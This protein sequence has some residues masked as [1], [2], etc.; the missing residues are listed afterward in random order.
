MATGLTTDTTPVPEGYTYV[1]LLPQQTGLRQPMYTMVKKEVVERDIDPETGTDRS[2]PKVRANLYDNRVSQYGIFQPRTKAEAENLIGMIN[3]E[4]AKENKNPITFNQFNYVTDQLANSLQAQEAVYEE[5]QKRNDPYKYYVQKF[6]D[7][8]DPEKH[9]NAIDNTASIFQLFRDPAKFAKDKKTALSQMMRNVIP[10]TRNDFVLAG[11]VVGSLAGFKGPKMP[12]QAVTGAKSVADEVLEG[13]IFKTTAGATLGGTAMSLTYDL[14]NAGIRKTMGIADPEDAPNAALEALTHGRNTLYFTGGAAG[15]MGVASTFRPFLGKALFGLD[16]PRNTLSN[17]A[18]LYD[19][20]VGISQMTRGAGGKLSGAAAAYFRVVGKIPFFGAGFQSRNTLAGIQLTKGMKQQLGDLGSGQSDEPLID[21]ISKSY[22]SLPRAV[23]KRMDTD[24]RNAGFRSYKDMVNAELRV[25]ELAPIQHMTDVGAFMFEEA[26]KRYKQFAY[27]NDLLY[28]D[29]ENKAKKISKNFIPTANTKAV[30]QNVRDELADATI[31]LENYSEFKPQLD[32]IENF[33]VESIANLPK[34][35]KPKD[36]RTIQREINR[37]YQEAEALIGPAAKKQG[38]PGGSLLA[39]LRKALTTDLNDYANWAPGLNTEEKI[40]AE[41]A[42]KSLYRANEVFSKMSP[43]YKSPAAKQFNLV[44][45]NLF[46]AGPD[47]PGYFY[48]D[49]IGKILFRDGLTPQRVR[50]YQALVGQNAFMT[51]VRSWINTG[52]KAALKDSPDITFEVLDKNS[53]TGTIKIT[54]KIMDIDKFKQN[55]NMSDEGFIEMMNLAGYNGKAFVDNMNQLVKLQELVKEAGIGT[56][57]SQLVARR[58]SLG[59]VRSAASTFSIFGSGAF[60]G[61][62]TGEGNFLGGGT[63]GAIMLG[64]LTRRTS[65]FLST[66]ESLK[67]YT[68]IIDPKASDVVKRSSL[69]NFLRGY[70]RQDEIKNDLPKEYN[71]PQKVLNDPDGFL[72]YLYNSEYLAVTDSVN[73][74]FMRDYMD[75]RYGD[76][77][78]IDINTIKNIDDEEN[79]KEDMQLGRTKV[80]E[81][82]QIMMPDIPSM[83]G[84]DVAQAS[85]VAQG[86][87]PSNLNADQR[88]A[89]AGGDLDEAIA[90]RN[91]T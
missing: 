73:D 77:L 37:L 2:L 24:A 70:L 10:G 44:D 5:M 53:K 51:G 91:R 14:I 80:L 63:A 6:K 21:Y 67:A 45:Q 43:L 55:I 18:Q 8:Y 3:K 89:L 35:V 90:L 38:T 85:T 86:P 57:T 52:F 64:L 25:N 20:P 83:G 74:G 23:R 50:D 28:T 30:A 84:E 32:A 41:S 22:K 12:G 58:L 31:R 27:I 16:G 33:V 17:F 62:Q 54:E 7:E 1:E 11:D 88:V 19:A 34:Y 68:K 49:E 61:A 72:D 69:V 9:R 29:F 47:L 87:A 46:T 71:T 15:L 26:G 76:N 40:L 65:R 56:S 59:G 81:S 82:E 42:K 79:V 78:D 39:K 13:S 60:A 4:R 75:E 66:P 48:S 36:I